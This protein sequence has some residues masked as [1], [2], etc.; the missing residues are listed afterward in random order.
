MNGEI[1]QFEEKDM[2][3][4][5]ASVDTS[6]VYIN[7]DNHT[8][9]TRISVSNLLAVQGATLHE[10]LI[11]ITERVTRQVAEEAI[12]SEEDQQGCHFGKPA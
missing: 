12:L 3:G 5:V 9:V 2:I 8:L 7:V 6:R 4:R 1:L 10:F 11:G